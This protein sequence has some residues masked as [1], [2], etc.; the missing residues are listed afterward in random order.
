[1]TFVAILWREW[2]NVRNKFVSITAS[3]LVSPLLYLIAF[4]WGVGDS[5]TIDGTSYTSFVMPAILSMNA[6]INGFSVIANDIN[7][8]RVYQKTFEAVMT[9]PIKMPVYVIARISAH[10]L[11]CLYGALLV[12]LLSFI[13]GAG[14]HPD[15]Y[16][17]L[18]L[19]L[20]CYVFSAAGF[21]AGIVINTHADVAKVSTF[22]ITPMAF[23]CGTFF[24]LE[25]FPAA[26]RALVSLLPLSQAVNGLRYG[27]AHSGW[28]PPLVLAV[29]LA[30]LLFIAIWICGRAE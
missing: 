7:M 4:G 8:T 20:N 17:F 23:L 30:V 10:V 6:A 26:L 19:I 11:R 14:L 22:F 18:V 1:M 21:I 28:T 5:F 29:Y 12:V 9:S 24:P 25:R 3:S 27:F 2:I 13:F 16:F 15:W